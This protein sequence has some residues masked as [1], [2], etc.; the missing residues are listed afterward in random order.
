MW[1]PGRSPGRGCGGRSPPFITKKNWILFFW[2]IFLFENFYNTF[3]KKKIIKIKKFSKSSETYAQ[4][5]FLFLTKKKVEYEDVYF[6]KIRWLSGAAT[7][8]RF[9]LLLPEIKQFMEIKK[10]KC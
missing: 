2:T 8:K 6:S 9:Q 5:I 4:F 7:L 1:G 3:S 10:T